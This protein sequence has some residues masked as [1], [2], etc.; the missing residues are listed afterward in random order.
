LKTRW[1]ESSRR[2]QP[3]K[4]PPISYRLHSNELKAQGLGLFFQ[5]RFGL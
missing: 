3:P 1:T 2:R 4:E 5:L